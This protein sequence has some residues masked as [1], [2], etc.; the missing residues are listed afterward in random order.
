[1]YR[2]GEEGDEE[3]GKGL[4]GRRKEREQ[5]EEAAEGDSRKEEEM[6]WGRRGEERVVEREKEAE[7]KHEV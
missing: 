6:R 1:M 2:C 4:E 7:L 3:E 5:G